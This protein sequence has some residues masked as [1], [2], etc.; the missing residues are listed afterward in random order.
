MNVKKNTNNLSV[1]DS[2]NDIMNR[3]YIVF[4]MIFF[5]CAVITFRIVSL[6]FIEGK[7]LRAK[8]DSLHYSLRPVKATRGNIL[9]DDSRSL[10]ATSLP[11]YQVNWDLTRIDQ[12]T[13]I[14]KLDSIV[15][16][17]MVFLE[18]E[19]TLDEL[20][21]R[22]I[23]AKES[24]EKYFLI[25]KGV[26]Y[27][28]L[29][30]L[31]KLP[32][33]REKR[34]MKSGLIVKELSKRQ[35]PF[36]M[37]AYRTI[38]YNKYIDREGTKE[39]DTLR[40]GLE[41]YWNEKLSGEEGKRWMQQISRGVWVPI[42]DISKVEPQA[43]KDIVTTINVDIQDVA[44]NA[45]LETLEKFEAEHGCAIVMDVKTGEIK[46]MANIGFNK[47]RTSFWEDYNYAIGENM[48]PG[49]TFK[50][51][52]MLAL[53]EDG[54]VK[55]ED[56]VNL[57]K[58]KWKFF[59]AVMED[60]SDHGFGM[61]TLQKA[62]EISSNVGISKM[63]HKYYNSNRK[64]QERFINKLKEL[65]V[66]K[67]TGIE[68]GG[69]KLPFLKTPDRADWSG[70]T[71]PWMSIGYELEMTPIQILTL[72]NAVANQGKMMKPQIVKEVRAYGKTEE[73]YDPLVVKNKIASRKTL[74]TLNYLLTQVV[75][76]DEGTAHNIYTKQYK[77]AGKTGTSIINWKSYQKGK[78][79]KKYRA[80]FVG[81][82]PADNPMYSCIVVVTNPQ[83]GKS[84]GSVAAPVFKKIADFC[85]ASTI[86]AHPALNKDQFVYTD[87]TL[88]AAQ[89]GFKKDVKQLLAHLKMPFVDNSDSEWSVGMVD[90]DTITLLSRSIKD[91]VVPNVI[92]LGLREALYLLENRR[93]RVMV[94]N[95]G[96]VI[97]QSIPAGTKIKSSRTI[98][99]VLK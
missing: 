13:F 9:A 84:G 43:G 23:R 12:N 97:S 96:K 26:N 65:G 95:K 35:Y 77:I 53:L 21:E 31:R 45:L 20:R 37:L 6:Q 90:H 19:Y 69:E 42:S 4:F 48:E 2:R 76:N 17:L 55:L 18:D 36:K 1:N 51:L 91:D 61:T 60:A 14:E 44:E 99:L 92:G 93:L 73:K 78:E 71:A 86:E 70:I 89:A 54:Y 28:E 87:A 68:I 50:M 46:A 25:K 7:N 38:G 3:V 81:Y 80:S 22:I 83:S 57:N 98:T 72:Y 24:K 75:E 29:E 64:Q 41:G 85:Y 15:S 67:P 10:L 33:F 58:G 49:S 5:G 27:V 40:I 11:Y 79:A 39:M 47:E 59:D 32:I 8:A 74:E 16:G 94:L 88:P 82:F 63:V 52:S 34:Q 30:E 62:F 56:T 66:N